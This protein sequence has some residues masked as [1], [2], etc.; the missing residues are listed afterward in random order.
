MREA[1][2]GQRNFEAAELGNTLRTAR[3][4]HSADA[5]LRHPQGTLPNK[6]A[7]PAD[8]KGFYGLKTGCGVEAL[9]FTWVETLE[10]AI[11]LLSV[12]AAELL[13]VRDAARDPMLSACCACEWVD[14]LSVRVLSVWRLGVERV[15]WSVKDYCWALARLG[16]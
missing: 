16:G 10:P 13:R 12:V 4:V 7:R 1:T 15:D 14:P 5:I 9:Q 6:F 3:L 8:L 2:F 11:G